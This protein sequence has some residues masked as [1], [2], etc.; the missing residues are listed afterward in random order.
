[1]KIDAGA[2]AAVPALVAYLNDRDAGVRQA[3]ADALWMIGVDARPAVPSLGACWPTENL[4]FVSRQPVPWRMGGKRDEVVKVLVEL[5]GDEK[6]RNAAARTLGKIGQEA[7]PAVAA[8]T[9]L[10][11]DANDHTQEA[12]ADALGEI[13]PES[14]SAIPGSRAFCKTKIG[15]CDRARPGLWALSGPRPSRV[16][17]R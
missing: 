14:R 17:R 15:L 12:A 2:K 10:L 13:G 4:R 11:T 9:R 3:A 7:K 8:L 6:V 16:Y 5:L 1:M